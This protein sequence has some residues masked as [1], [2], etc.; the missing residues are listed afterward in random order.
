MKR[1]V[2][3][4]MM[5]LDEA[6][7][8]F[9]KRFPSGGFREPEECLSVNASGRVSAKPIFA[10]LSTPR[11]H[12]AAMDGYAVRAEDTFGAHPKS[13]LKLKIGEQAFPVNTGFPLPRGTNAVVMIEDVLELGGEEI[14]IESP[15]YPWQNV[16]KVG[17]DVVATELLYPENHL[18]S[19]YDIGALLA[20]GVTRVWVR[21]RP[22]VAI[23]P[24][25]KELVDWPIL[26]SQGVIGEHQVVEFNSFMLS[27]MVKGWGAEP[28]RLDIVPDD[29]YRLRT[30]IEEALEDCDVVV[31]NAGSSAGSEDMTVQVIEEMGEVVTHGISM[32]PGKPTILATVKGKPVVGNPGYPVSAVISC[33]EIL[34]PLIGRLLGIEL[35]P[36]PKVRAT[37]TRKLPCKAGIQEFVRVR[38]GDVEGTITATPLPRAAGSITS[39]TRADGILRVPEEVEGYAEGEEVWVELLRSP[40]EIRKTLV[41]IGSHDLTLDLINNKLRAKGGGWT[42]ASSNVG[43][44]G[45]LIAVRK[46]QA[47]LAGTHLLDPQTGEY[48][49]PYIARFLQ[50]VRVKLVHLVEREQG[51]MVAK[52]NP[53]GIQTIEDLT[54]PEVR[55][56]NRQAG[57]GTRVLLDYLL[58]KLG[59]DSSQIKGYSREEYTHMAIAVAIASGT[60]DVG[61]GILAAA[62]ALDLDFIPIASERYDLV[63]PERFYYKEGIQR[64]LEIIRSEHF[65]E[66]V[67]GMGGYNAS[68]SGEVII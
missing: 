35:P 23:I 48:N 28:V 24:T 3:L 19:P 44:M 47:H 27:E 54:K 38:L 46:G 18:F 65:R 61:M 16:R 62:R 42:L 34:R 43:S 58:E 53:L 36:R 6:K 20:A 49:L 68:R 15:V 17:E 52:G 40:E 39:L 7:E 37:M 8:A 22:K 21:P 60:A 11:Y 30:A 25:G 2:Y 50:G 64:L 63:I 33:E 32:M 67:E 4:K 12:S 29:P 9:L 5:S 10:R 1:R 66:A 59:I 31:I 57:S 51:L 13:P 26:D 56:V 55:F 45:G 14:Q 41:A